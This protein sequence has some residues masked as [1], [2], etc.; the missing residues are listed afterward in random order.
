ML[1]GEDFLNNWYKSINMINSAVLNSDV[2]RVWDN[3]IAPKWMKCG[4]KLIASM[5]KNKW[6]IKIQLTNN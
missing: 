1:E 4:N 3:S 6:V 2:I 5:K